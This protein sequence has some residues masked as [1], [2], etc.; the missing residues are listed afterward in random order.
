MAIS[1]FY[2][3]HVNGDLIYKPGLDAAADIRESDFARAMWPM[4]PED[5]AGAWNI[6]VEGLALGANR[7][8]V[9]ELAAKWGC[10]N[11]DALYYA[12]YL[13]FELV[14]DG[15]AWCARPLWFIN[16]QESPAGFGDTCLEASAGLCKELGY[17]GS[18]MWNHTFKSLLAKPVVAA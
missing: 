14:K 1:G 11:A 7:H 16:P 17:K 2:Y 10:T 13:G 15:T 4:D 3:L 8:R 18:K 9:D 12:E 5:R 6:V